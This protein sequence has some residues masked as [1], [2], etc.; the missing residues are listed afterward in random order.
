MTEQ[1]FTIDF[2]C[3]ATN[4]ISDNDINRIRNGE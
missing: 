1:A 3:G 2:N 4:V